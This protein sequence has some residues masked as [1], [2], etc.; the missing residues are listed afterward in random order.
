MNN[1]IGWTMSNFEEG[2]YYPIRKDS[3]LYRVLVKAYRASAQ[4]QI[5][6]RKKTRHRWSDHS[7]K[8]FTHAH[9]LIKKDPPVGRGHYQIERHG[10]NELFAV[11]QGINQQFFLRFLKE[12]D[13]EKEEQK[14]TQPYGSDTSRVPSP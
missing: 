2:I 12:E 9:W 14:E 6:F 1:Q 13:N 7:N 4:A 11:S 10:S 5:V 3:H 8:L